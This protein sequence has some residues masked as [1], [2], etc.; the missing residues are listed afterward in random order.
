M[1]LEFRP[2]K[3][4]FFDT[5]DEDKVSEI[6]ST[7]RAVVQHQKKE[8]TSK[9]LYGIAIVVDDF[10]D[11]QRVMASRTGSGGSAINMRLTRGRHSF[12]SVYLS[13]AVAL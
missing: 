8:K 7:Q 3:K 9:L 12:C 11:D 2:T 1:S 5:W 13:Q 4:T 6:L 10:A